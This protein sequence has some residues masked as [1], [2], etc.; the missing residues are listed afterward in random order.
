MRLVTLV[1]LRRGTNTFTTGRCQFVSYNEVAQTLARF[2]LDAHIS[3][4]SSDS[5]ECGCCRHTSLHQLP[6]E[7]RD[8]GTCE[9]DDAWDR[10][11]QWPY[12]IY[13]YM[14]LTVNCVYTPN[15]VFVLLMC[16][17]IFNSTYILSDSSHTQTHT[18]TVLLPPGGH[19]L[20]RFSCWQNRIFC[21]NFYSN[22]STLYNP[23]EFKTL[24]HCLNIYSF[25]NMTNFTLPIHD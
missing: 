23:K 14:I 7:S 12:I 16:L 11:Y 25:W 22:I 17:F 8:E 3:D 5:N 10:I 15:T 13:I 19:T 24:L 6:V 21:S 4:V 1:Y 2:H 9:W 20:K 18:H